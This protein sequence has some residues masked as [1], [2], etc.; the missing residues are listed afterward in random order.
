M[1][2][3]FFIALVQF[4]MSLTSKGFELVQN[5]SKKVEY[6]EKYNSKK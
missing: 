4:V 6:Q 3:L 5:L 2:K 1:I